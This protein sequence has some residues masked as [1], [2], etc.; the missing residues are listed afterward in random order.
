[1]SKGFVGGMVGSVMTAGLI[2]A[3]LVL[4]P[5]LR[6]IPARF[7]VRIAAPSP[8]REASTDPGTPETEATLRR[9]EAKYSRP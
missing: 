7:G 1:M 4:F 6:D 9:L 2:A 8:L 5:S 3:A